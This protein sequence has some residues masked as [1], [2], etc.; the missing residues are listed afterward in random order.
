MELFALYFK[1]IIY[2]YHEYKKSVKTKLNKNILR[3]F[4]LMS[5]EQKFY[6]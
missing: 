3:F 5:K 6:I 4:S 1:T 2:C